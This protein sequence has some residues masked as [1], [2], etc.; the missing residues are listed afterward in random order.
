MEIIYFPA[1]KYFCQQNESVFSSIHTNTCH[2][3]KRA[4]NYFFSMEIILSAEFFEC[5]QIQIWKKYNVCCRNIAIANGLYSCMCKVQVQQQ[6]CHGSLFSSSCGAADAVNTQSF[7]N[8]SRAI[9]GAGYQLAIN[10]IVDASTHQFL[11]LY[12]EIYLSLSAVLQRM[13]HICI[14]IL[15]L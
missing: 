9:D 4:S 11:H 14:C 13:H 3:H 2:I 8:S 15:I 5:T 1:W 12:F 7:R 10:S 6:M